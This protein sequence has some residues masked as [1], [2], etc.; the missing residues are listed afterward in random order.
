MSQTGYA[1]KHPLSET[2]IIEEEVVSLITNLDTEKSD[3]EFDL[4]ETLF[5]P[6]TWTTKGSLTCTFWELPNWLQD[7]NDI[8]RGYRRPTFSYLKCIQ[9]LFY[10][11][12]ESVNIW[13]HFV[14][15]ILFAV[16]SLATYFYLMDYNTLKQSDYIAFY[17]FMAGA[18]I[19][20]GLSSS[21]HTMCCHSEKVCANWNRCDYVGIVALIIATISVAVALRFRRPE[22]RWFRTGL[23]FALGGSSVIPIIHATLLYGFH[24]SYE[25]ISL[26]WLAITGLLYIFGAFL[27]GTRIPERLFPGKFD[28]WGSSHQFFHFFV[29]AAAVV[30]YYGVLHSMLYWHKANNQCTLSIEE[31]QQ[32][33]NN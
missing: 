28:I 13:S 27:Y 19:C 33:L 17:C 30:H 20:L 14:G 16:L 15:A 26:K 25:V 7:N 12:N 24:L 31:M 18:M 23:F 1:P 9:S 29:V 22:F 32:N 8:I 21:F 2:K 11:H 4:N 3:E 10:L 5:F 6:T